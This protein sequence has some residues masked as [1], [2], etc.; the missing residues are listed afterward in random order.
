M[1]LA[2]ARNKTLVF[3]QN[4]RINSLREARRDPARP[5]TKA[6]AVRPRTAWSVVKNCNITR[7][8]LSYPAA[9]AGG[10]IPGIS[11]VPMAIIS[12]SNVI[13]RRPCGLLRI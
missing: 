1:I 11:F 9:I 4:Y 12:V 2:V 7:K 10:R 3:W 6:A 8:P 13:I 5:L